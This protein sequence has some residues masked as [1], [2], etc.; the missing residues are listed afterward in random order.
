MYEDNDSGTSITV[1]TG[2]TYYG[3]ITAAGG[4][5]DGITFSSDATADRLTVTTGGKYRIM[6]NAAYDAGNSDQTKASIFLDGVEQSDLQWHRTMGA[7]AA[8]G[9]AGC[10]GILT[11]TANQYIDLRFTSNTNSDV[12]NLYHVQVS[13]KKIG[14]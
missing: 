10:N 3:W 7:A 6:A 8:V 4:P 11:M 14:N 1:V 13:I 2:G 9:S 12:I 5:E